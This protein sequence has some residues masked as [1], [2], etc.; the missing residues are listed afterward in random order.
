VVFV[1]KETH[2]S[3]RPVG[4]AIAVVAPSH[5]LMG[6]SAAPITQRS[7]FVFQDLEERTARNA[8]LTEEI[9]FESLTAVTVKVDVDELT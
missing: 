5:V 7:A 8:N 3:A 6:D 1:C 9:R 2:A 4:M